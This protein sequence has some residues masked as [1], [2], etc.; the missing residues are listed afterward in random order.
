[1][2]FDLST[3]QTAIQAGARE[4]LANR[5][6]LRAVRRHAEAG[7]YDADLWTAVVNQ[8]WTGIAVPEAD[9]GAGLGYVELALVAE[10]FGYACA[11]SPFF[12]NTAAGIMLL[13]A[14]G[15]QAARW[16]PGI[17]AGD[18]RGAVGTMT[19]HGSALVPDAADAAVIVL[20]DGDRASVVARADAEIEPVAAIDITRPYFRVR[21]S[22]G[23][24]LVGDVAAA[25]D[26][27]EVLLSAELTGVATRALEMAVEYA[28]QRTQFN[29]P[30]GAYQAVSHRLA[31]MLL[32]V[33]S[34][35]SATYY[36]AWTADAE[37]GS[38]AQAAAVAKATAADAGWRVTSSALQVHGGIGF[39]WEHDLQFF[40]KRAAADARLFGSVSAHRDRVAS[41]YGLGGPAP[42]GP[43]P[44]PATTG[45]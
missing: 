23:Q 40:L 2:D 29:R 32:A 26:R 10:E 13:T 17:L 43:A 15:E 34:S 35:R 5:S 12:S 30:I 21:S 9:G 31:D 18:A 16:L 8:G 24:P 19:S 4:F 20:V 27:V 14:G 37:P 36:A 25:L 6:D 3:E 45:A 28:R 44:R 1:M 42:G 7:T 38:L 39:T 41:G 33:E 22:A 11:P